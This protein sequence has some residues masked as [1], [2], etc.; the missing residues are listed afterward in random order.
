MF[1]CKIRNTL[2][3]VHRTYIRNAVYVQQ[4][5]DK[6]VVNFRKTT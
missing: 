5:R 1:N 6:M 3:P 4:C 2:A